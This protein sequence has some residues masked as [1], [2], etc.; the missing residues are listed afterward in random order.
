M[1]R[2]GV[3]GGPGGAPVPEESLDPR[4]WE[5]MRALGRRMVDDMVDYLRTVR[6]RPPW[7][8]APDDVIE[9]FRAELPLDGASPEEIY[10]EFRRYVLPYP[11][12]NIHPRFWGWVHG[13]GT[14]F[15]AFAELLGA[16]M[17]PNTGGRDFHSAVYVERQVI[18]WIKEMLHFPPGAGGILTTG[19]SAANLI[20]LAVARHAKAGFDVREEGLQ[21]ARPRRMVYASTEIHGSVQKAVELL[22]LGRESLRHLPVDEGFRV[23]PEAIEEAI[24]RDRE[25]GLRPFCIA[26]AAGTTNTG[27]IDDLARLADIAA[28]EGLWFHVDASFGAWAAIVPDLRSPVDGM[29]RADSI[30]FD[31]HKWMYLPYD[32]GGV[33]VRSDELHRSAFSL[34][35]PYLARGKGGRGLAGGD[36]PWFTDYGFELSR[37]FRALKV[38]MSLKEHGVRKYA[39]LIRQNVEQARYL[40]GLVAAAPE[41]ELA[42]PVPLNI[43]CFRYAPPGT[44]PES[45]DPINRRIVIELQERGIAVPSGTTLRGHY[46]IRAAITNHRSRREDF[47][48][49]VKEA[50]RIGKESSGE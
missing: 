17:N 16:S 45:L 32:I 33:L 37:G 36:I 2:P 25:A 23:K 7:R 11:V 21:G 20:G 31:L 3:P 47:D 4:D 41:L 5:A 46:V 27:A 12:G 26:G 22:G 34:M 15:G 44:P 24:R 6:E 50:I 13:T 42:A 38:W 43:V 35:P 39:R 8:H 40:A 1:D 30:A 14:L 9:R 28:R 29:E 19:C 48:L 18:D 10:E 49:L